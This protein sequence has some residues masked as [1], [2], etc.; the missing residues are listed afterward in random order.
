MSEPTTQALIG[1]GFEGPL[2]SSVNTG[3]RE[4][5]V[6]GLIEGPGSR[7]RD[8]CRVY[9]SVEKG[10]RSSGLQAKGWREYSKR[11]E[12]VSQKGGG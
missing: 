11:V 1:L 3:L 2:G 9:C 7:V 5:K 4:W 6:K 8:N 10:L 12:G